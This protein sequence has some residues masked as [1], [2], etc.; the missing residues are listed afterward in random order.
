[1]DKTILELQS[2]HLRYFKSHKD[3]KIE[4]K[5]DITTI[6]GDNETGKS[7]I[8]DAF[9]WLFFGK[10]S[11]DRSDKNFNIKTITS[12]TG[13]QIKR[14][15]H[16]VEAVFL[17]NGERTS[18]MRVLKEKWSKKKGATEKV[19]IGNATDY[20]WNDVPLSKR[21]YEAKI[22]QFISESVFKMVTDPFAFNNLHWEK[23]RNILTELGVS[24]TDEQI[25]KGNSD[26]IKLMDKLTNK[27]FEEYKT[28]MKN[29]LRRLKN[30]KQG[31][32]ARID[33]LLRDKPEEI[34]F[35]AIEKEIDSL[36]KS[37]SSIDDKIADK[38]KLADDLHKEYQALRD[39]LSDLK[40]KKQDIELETKRSVRE[41]VDAIKNPSNELS[42]KIIQIQDEVYDYQQGIDKLE[43]SILSDKAELKT[44]IEKKEAKS[45][46]WDDKNAEEFRVDS[47]ALNCPT[48]NKPFDD[49][50]KEKL[51][52][53]M[54]S[55][56][57]SQKQESLTQINSEG[58]RL[59]KQQGELE[60]IISTNKKRVA[61]GNSKL[62]E[63]QTELDKLNSELE[64]L[65][66]NP[67]EK[68]DVEDYTKKRLGSN[69]EYQSILQEI[70]S[71]ESKLENQ[72]SVDVSEF[73]EERKVILHQLD[74][75]KSQL[76]S[77]SEIERIDNRVAELEAEEQD[78]A[79]HIADAEK[80]LNTIQEFEIARME[81]I[82]GSVNNKFKK[83]KF[84]MFSELIDGTKTPDCIC[85]YK[86]I[87]FPDVNTAGQIEAGLDIIDALCEFYNTQTTI[88]ID[89]AESITVI[90]ETISQQVHLRVVKGIKPIK[91]K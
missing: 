63:K 6:E 1:M 90:P 79:Q 55:E 7:T 51:I 76:N 70:E 80:E 31:I 47:E 14:V 27:S 78:N 72:K 34:D 85:T 48:C 9:T 21:D 91:V 54:Q 49:D 53:N 89:K 65:R 23:Q 12:S 77:K 19:F 18:A 56:F 50:K 17:L 64:K 68:P 32:P 29:Q 43:K 41:E 22:S 10:D 83:V 11:H 74:N 44:V 59:K 62:K 2:L 71:T 73:K 5:P 40:S 8:F 60:R 46:K 42:R 75:N 39:K 87:P 45:K 84:R 82:E 25:A 81:A 16:S 66:K 35:D 61:E 36:N 3:L 52:G 15:E 4:F 38:N 33:E 88:F 24:V 20:Y 26:F 28:Q 37:L 69:K 13:E 57:N 30:D 86:G 67:V 58:Q